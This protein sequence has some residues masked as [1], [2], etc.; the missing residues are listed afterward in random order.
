MECWEYICVW[1]HCSFSCYFSKCLV[2]ALMCCYV[3]SALPLG[4]LHSPS[5]FPLSTSVSLCLPLSPS[6]SLCLSVSLCVPLS[7]TERITEFLLQHVV[8]GKHAYV[9]RKTNKPMRSL[10]SSRPMRSLRSSRTCPIVMFRTIHLIWYITSLGSEKNKETHEVF[11]NQKYEIEDVVI[12]K[13][14][15]SKILKVGLIQSVILKNNCL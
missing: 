12:L 13:N 14:L 10:G 11:R 8:P 4:L 1:S 6:F 15:D 9:P 3:L 5:A 7:R 2:T